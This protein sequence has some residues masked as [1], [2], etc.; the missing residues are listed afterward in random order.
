MMSIHTYNQLLTAKNTGSVDNITPSKL[1]GSGSKGTKG[2]K[3]Y[4]TLWI[5]DNDM[6]S[7]T[8]DK[9]TTDDRIESSYRANL[10]K[11]MNKFDSHREQQEK[12]ALTQIEERLEREY[13]F[14]QVKTSM[15][16]MQEKVPEILLRDAADQALT[17]L[18]K[19]SSQ[20]SS[21][22]TK[23]KEWYGNWLKTALAD[24]ENKAKEIRKL[25]REVTK[26]DDAFKE[27]ENTNI[28]KD[29]TIDDLE[30]EIMKLKKGKKDMDKNYEVLEQYADDMKR[31]AAK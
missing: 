7:T 23:V 30:Q 14:Y 22:L 20:H 17:R 24:A 8:T 16:E 1:T 2:Y 5:N 3:N 31:K 13:K 12:K 21:L 9:R 29:H 27:S 26:L 19:L 15:N 28:I 18:S 11:N 4:A 10:Q 6:M 25:K